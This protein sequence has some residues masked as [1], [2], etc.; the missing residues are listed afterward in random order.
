LK[1]ISFPVPNGENNHSVVSR[2]QQYAAFKTDNDIDIDFEVDSGSN[3]E[4]E[5][6]VDDV[7]NPDDDDSSEEDEAP[8]CPIIDGHT[9]PGQSFKSLQSIDKPTRRGPVLS[10]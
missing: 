3:A 5:G 8:T 4:S 7:V 9:R 6:D 2:E 10:S 1:D